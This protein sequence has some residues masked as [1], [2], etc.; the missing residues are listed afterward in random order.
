MKKIYIL[1]AIALVAGVSCTKQVPADNNSPDMPIGFSPIS[2]RTGTKANVYGEQ[3]ATYT[4]NAPTAYEQFAT[5]AFFTNDRSTVSGYNPQ[6]ITTGNGQEFFGTATAG[7]TSTHQTT[8]SLNTD[9]WQPL[10]ASGNP[11]FWPKNGYLHF[12]ALSPAVY[13]TGTLAHSWANGIS[14]TGYV[15]PVYTDANAT[16]L[17]ADAVQVDLLYSDFVF[18][19]QR[20]QYNATTNVG[21][22]YDNEDDSGIYKH[23][24]VNILFRHALSLVQFKVKTDADYK[25]ASSSQQHKF[26]VRKIEIVNAYNTGNF[27]ENRTNQADNTYDATTVADM[28]TKI[29]FNKLNPNG[30]ATPY[31]DTFSNEVT[32]TPYDETAGAAGTGTEATSTISSQ[33]GTTIIAL[34]QYLAHGTNDVKVKVTFDYQ[35]SSD[36]GSNWSSPY[37]QTLEVNLGGKTGTYGTDTGDYTVNNWLINHK[38]IYTLVFKLDPIIFDPAVDAFVTVDGIT[39]ELPQA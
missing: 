33:V 8:A 11:Y 2:Q 31:W 1:A 35:F 24:G 18:D 25:A 36:A 15:A 37:T 29:G 34:P 12:H 10:D 4:A 14:I 6:D 32:L 38:Y 22:Y 21:T 3:N 26:F 9:Y 7:V 23:D 16:G 28:S 17:T 19:Q 39:V 30:A 5:W 13:G 27:H 20:S